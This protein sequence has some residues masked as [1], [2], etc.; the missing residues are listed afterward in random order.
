MSAPSSAAIATKEV[1]SVTPL[2]QP[3]SV[4]SD[5][6][7]TD[8]NK[9]APASSPAATS[10]TPPPLTDGLTLAHIFLEGAPIITEMYGVGS[11]RSNAERIVEDF[12]SLLDPHENIRVTYFN[13]EAAKPYRMPGDGLTFAMV[14]DSQ[15]SRHPLADSDT[16][17]EHKVP[18]IWTVYIAEA[19]STHECNRLRIP[20]DLVSATDDDQY[21]DDVSLPS[22]FATSFPQSFPFSGKKGQ[23]KSPA[24]KE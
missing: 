1:A 5:S 3:S 23:K 9:S 22:Q 6:S 11:N 10:E 13:V 2:E 7:T 8:D 21:S 15:P 24:K 16:E 4:P 19:F 20:T 17:D 18:L 12:R 14:A